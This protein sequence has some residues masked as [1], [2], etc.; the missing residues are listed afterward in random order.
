[1][2]RFKKTK[3]GGYV[4]TITGEILHYEQVIQIL[5]EEKRK[6]SNLIDCELEQI[7]IEN[8]DFQKKDTHRFS[9]NNNSGN[10]TLFV[11]SY[12]MFGREVKKNMSINEK[13]LTFTLID[14]LETETN[15]VII[16]GD[17]PTN[18][19]IGDLVGLK[20]TAVSNTIS[21]LKKKNI[22]QTKGRGKGRQIYIN[23]LLVFDGKH[24]EMET[25]KL[26]NLQ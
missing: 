6:T 20:N 5:K 23:P 2:K 4:D 9:W 8:G 16:D 25:L 15:R 13:A 24:V 18:K 11:K 21:S 12:K 3:L 14:Y 1:M 19:Q 26:F 10:P 22:I 7:Q 17:N